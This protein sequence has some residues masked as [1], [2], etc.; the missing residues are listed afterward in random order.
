MG[1]RKV[2]ALFLS[3]LF[4]TGFL[5]S[6]GQPVA[7]ELI[8]A[9]ASVPPGG[10]TTIAARFRIKPGWHI[11]AQKPGDAGL[12]TKV[13]WEAPPEVKIGPLQWPPAQQFLEAGDLKTSGYTDEVIAA[14]R[15]TVSAKAAP[16]P[17]LI[18]A[19]VEWLACKDL[20]VPGRAQLD[21]SLPV[22]AAP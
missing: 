3:V 14:S 18:H 21:L 16:A 9:D 10:R 4:L 13:T 17:L 22:S 20:C 1:N 2:I 12:P 5:S 11:Y 6:Q 19:K 7:V 15:L 8:A